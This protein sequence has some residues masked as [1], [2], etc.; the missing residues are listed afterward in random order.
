MRSDFEGRLCIILISRVYF[1]VFGS[2]FDIIIF[3][4]W[5]SHPLN[6][7]VF[8][9]FIC[10]RQTVLIGEYSASFIEVRCQLMSLILQVLLRGVIPLS[11]SFH[12]VIIVY[13]WYN[14]R[15]L[16]HP[17]TISWE[18]VLLDRT[19][20]IILMRKYRWSAQILHLLT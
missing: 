17:L 16:A 12:Q 4:K 3:L 7:I 20:L 11:I 19:L 13:T 10:D 5:K 9:I 8:V 15:F 1:A 6:F 18:L 14:C 2:H